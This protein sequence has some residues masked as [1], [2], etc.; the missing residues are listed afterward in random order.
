M[1]EDWTLSEAQLLERLRK[2]SAIFAD[3]VVE[4]PVMLQDV[5]TEFRAARRKRADLGL[6]NHTLNLFLEPRNPFEPQRMRKPK[7]EATVF[8]TLL[9]LVVIALLSFNLAAPRP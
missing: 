7:M 3:I 2:R 4:Q 1:L 5:D 9:A 8:G 6:L